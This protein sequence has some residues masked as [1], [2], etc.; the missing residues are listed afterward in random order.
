M[1]VKKVY[2]I[3]ISVI[4]LLFAKRFIEF[5]NQNLEIEKVK[6]SFAQTILNKSIKVIDSSY[7]LIEVSLPTKQELEE[8]H[9]FIEKMA[10]N[11]TE[12]NKIIDSIIDSSTLRASFFDRIKNWFN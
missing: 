1:R 4:L 12:L 9:I 2:L 3:I 6:L 5:R 8:Y 10:K 7:N 11:Q